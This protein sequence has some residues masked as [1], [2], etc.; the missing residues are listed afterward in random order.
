VKRLVVGFIMTGALVLLLGCTR[1]R[2][3]AT[4]APSASTGSTLSPSA[5]AGSTTLS[6]QQVDWRAVA[7]PIDCGG[8]S[9]SPGYIAYAIPDDGTELAI[10]TVSCD[11]GAGSPPS[12]IFAYDSTGS[13][14]NPHLAET[15]VTT[16]D[17]WHPDG[18][19]LSQGPTLS[20]P[21]YGYSGKTARCCPDI[22][23]TL[24]WSW[25]GTSY[26]ET[27]PEPAHHQLPG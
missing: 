13:V 8:M 10:L 22:R 3:V 23:T 15:L 5:S 21:V 25:N 7:Y 6:L 18:A 9:S 19:I 11:A 20:I 2:V 14:A 12:A 24:T 27:S 1:G 16:Q 4:Q 26:K 17:D